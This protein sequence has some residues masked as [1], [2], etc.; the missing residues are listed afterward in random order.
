HP[1]NRDKPRYCGAK[2]HGRLAW[3]RR[4]PVPGKKRCRLH[5]GLSTGAKTPEGKARVLA[6][7]TEGRRRWIAQMKAEG[8]KFPW[9]RKAGPGWT[10]PRMWERQL[11]AVQQWRAPPPRQARAVWRAMSL[12]ERERG[13]R[14]AAAT[15]R[16]SAT[17][18][19]YFTRLAARNSR[20]TPCI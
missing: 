12:E 3:C 6:A 7:L 4:W 1:R 15:G 8:R 17:Y 19:D 9:G 18:K 16:R 5:G 11:R 10:T 14:A 20:C 13:M 2:R